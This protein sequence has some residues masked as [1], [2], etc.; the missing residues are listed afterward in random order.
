M[1]YQ[2]L[3]YLPGV[4]KVDSA[5]TNSIKMAYVAGRGAVG[6]ITDMNKARFIA[7]FPEKI[8]GR[9]LFYPS[10]LSGI[11]R[12]H[13]AW[14]D[15]MQNVYLAIGTTQ[16][17]Y[18]IS[19]GTLINATP[20]RALLVGAL[21]NP[22]TT[23]NN[24]STV[25]IAHTAHG[26]VT[27]DY[28]QLT[29]GTIFNNILLAGTFPITVIDAND[30]TVVANS[31]ANASSGGSPGGGTVDY[32]YYRETVATPLSTTISTP[33]V[34]VTI[35]A[36]GAIQG[37]T[38]IVT[39]ASAIGG[40]TPNGT[41]TITSVIDANNFT[42]NFT[43]NATSSVNNAGGSPNFQ[44]EISVGAA[45]G[46]SSFG[47]GAG[48]Y[49]AGGY[50]VGQ[51][52]TTFFL[53]ARTWSL[54]NYGQQLLANEY[55]GSIYVW[56]PVIQGRAFQLYGAPTQVN[57][58]FV[59]PERYVFALGSPSNQMQLQWP[60]QNDDTDWVPALT[61]TADQRTLNFGSYLVGGC[62]V[63]D[64]LSMVW[65]NIAAYTF[66]YS[67]DTFIYDS[68]T[69][70]INC[71]LAGPLARCVVGGVVFWFGTSELWMW[72]GSVSPIGTDD[73]RDYVFGNININQ[74]SKFWVASNISK[75]EVWFGYCS[76]L[77]TEIDS[78]VIYH[79]DQGCWSIGTWNNTFWLDRGLFLNPISSDINGFLYYQESGTDDNG[80]AIDSWV[81]YNPMVISKGDNQM[82]IFGFLPDFER[83]TGALTL[84]PTTQN[85]P[86]DTPI[87]NGPFI[88][89]P[90]DA[91]PLI[92]L[93]LSGRM[94]GYK[95]ESNVLGGDYR[96]GLCQVN[97]QPGAG[98]R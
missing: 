85:Y 58:M 12:G 50:G 87:N 72:N 59:T 30:Y 9:T 24:S 45:S 15:L 76:A 8:G 80:T 7:G 93:R 56:D 21:T 68:T 57:A 42:Y 1:A 11:P 39:G 69:A 25:S 78:Y 79:I 3:S 14:R 38:V 74:A 52:T 18:V 4:C 40:I 81:T 70:G 97:V 91:T 34:K 61:N 13:F 10:A 41:F 62:V 75:K 54:D 98:R 89:S 84:T 60:D 26:L 32:V 65:S 67:G 71:G 2:Q 43:S 48:N 17:L 47:Y 92:D 83:Q 94:A 19:A 16:K 36:H 86:E 33:T 82:D 22:I 63:R 31:V 51:T 49:G 66:T 35:T 88:L 23:T 64:G 90:N 96:V 27:G 37:D 55:G 95:I 44:F 5:Y 46:A 6:R 20:L 77:S 53:A 29:Q 73:I 28:V